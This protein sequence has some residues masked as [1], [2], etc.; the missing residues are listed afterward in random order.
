MASFHKSIIVYPGL[1]ADYR[2]E[3]SAK[4]THRTQDNTKEHLGSHWE[5]GLTTDD[6]YDAES[7][8]PS[9]T[10]LP[11]ELTTREGVLGCDYASVNR[12]AGDQPE[13]PKYTIR[14]F[15]ELTYLPACG[16]PYGNPME[17]ITRTSR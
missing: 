7:D 13:R 14:D 12:A 9:L 5:Q 6:R 10:L 2:S 8:N 11:E 1:S 4:V 16:V 17:G 15:T 3:K